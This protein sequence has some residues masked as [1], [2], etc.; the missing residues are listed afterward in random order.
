M[1]SVES[2]GLILILGA[3]LAAGLSLA[4]DM[5]P[6]LGRDDSTVDIRGNADASG[7]ALKVGRFQRSV[8]VFALGGV[9]LES[10]SR[11]RLVL[12]VKEYP[13]GWGPG[14]REGKCGSIL[15]HIPSCGEVPFDE[16]DEEN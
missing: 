12:T 10:L 14:R 16:T 2:R 5:P 1:R 11:A 4:Q 6:I 8:V 9:S 15:K 3:A 13:G 7:T